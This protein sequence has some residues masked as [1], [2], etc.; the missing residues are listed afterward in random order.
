[1]IIPPSLQKGDSVYL[2]NIARKGV[3]DT[4]FVEKTFR[5]WG[6]NPVLGETVSTDG[7]CQFAAEA[8]LRLAD[9]QKALDNPKI[10]AIF[11]L[12]GG[13]GTV[14]ILDQIDFTAFTENPKWLVGYSDIT[15]L[16][17]HINRN[18]GIATLHAA[19]FSAWHT[20]SESDLHSLRA[21]LFGESDTLVFSDV[22]SEKFRETTGEVVGGNLSI[23]HTVIG[24]PSDITTDGKILFLEDVFENLMSIERMLWAMKRS[25]KFKGLKALLLGDFLIPV[26]DNETSNCMVPEIP[27][28]DESSIQPAFRK[29]ILNFFREYD[30]PICFGLS[31]GH[32][33]ARNT[34]VVVGKTVHLSMK[35]GN[36]VL[37]GK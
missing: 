31:I 6:L 16:H 37:S 20:A 36:L 18:F 35:N 33:T 29:M 13:Y 1:M 19:M 22:D 8:S 23:L 12:R 9:F 28:P 4:A 24:T 7:Y 27:V 2:V 10:K 17:A 25:G 3:Y 30:F 34:A 21:Q 15:Y 5:D 32:T 14:Q 11:F 26:K